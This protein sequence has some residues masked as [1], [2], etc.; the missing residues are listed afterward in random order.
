MTDFSDILFLSD[1]DLTLSDGQ[2][3]PQRNLD[4]IE[5][6]KAG[7][8]MFSIATGRS[9]PTFTPQLEKIS[10]NAPVVLSNGSLVY[11][12]ADGTTWLQIPM[13]D[14]EKAAVRRIR[15]RHSDRAVFDLEV[16]LEVY[17]PNDTLAVQANDY[18]R[19]HF[20]WVGMVSR[21]CPMEEIPDDWMKA[22]FTAHPDDI[23]T[24][25]KEAEEE[26]LNGVRSLP[27]M[28]EIQTGGVDKGTSARWLAD[29]LGRKLVCAGD[30]PNDTA[31]LRAA[32]RAFVPSS[33][34]PEILAMG[35]EVVA[36]CKTGAIADA[37][38][39]MEAERR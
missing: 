24:L 20:E 8:G 10:V 16:G 39:R 34:Y 2:Q 7:G 1:Y 4:A 14:W 9:K 37:I 19:A 31:L 11:D 38:E 35:Y 25:A 33:A 36:D 6:F 29:R 27:F 15:D 12:F 28:L 21:M 26:G 5:R 30:A 3:I 13:K 18:T 17:L 32:D 22:V 23:P